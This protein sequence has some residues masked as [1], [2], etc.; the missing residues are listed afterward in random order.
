MP[1]AARKW[2]CPNH[3]DQVMP[4]R[5]TVRNGLETVDVESAGAHNNGNVSVVEAPEVE[6]DI[7]TDDMVIN[8][9]KYRVPERI[10]Q[11]DF[12]NK[13]RAGH[14]REAPAKTAVRE[15]RAQRALAEA[16]PQ[17]LEAAK[18]LVAMGLVDA[19]DDG[20]ADMVDGEVSPRDDKD[21]AVLSKRMGKEAANGARTPVPGGGAGGRHTRTS[22]G[23]N[24]SRAATPV[25]SPAPAQRPGS[26]SSDAPRRITLRVGPPSQ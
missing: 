11:L 8:N 6:P 22:L 5:R 25:G 10:I 14:V 9:K 4:R 19:D 26:G 13:L 15:A 7:P 2:M 1:S 18:L 3:S 24:G 23:V 20:D 12:F 17:E 21:E 16:S